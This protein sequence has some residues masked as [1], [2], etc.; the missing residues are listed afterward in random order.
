MKQLGLS[1]SEH[2]VQAMMR[3]VGVGPHGKICYPGISHIWIT[4]ICCKAIFVY[5]LYFWRCIV[6]QYLNII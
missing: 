6:F 5:V 2:D 4:W 3:S 1:L